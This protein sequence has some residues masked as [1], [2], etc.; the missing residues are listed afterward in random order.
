MPPSASAIS[1]VSSDLNLVNVDGTSAGNMLVRN[2][3]FNPAL[4]KDDPT[5][6]DKLLQGAATQRL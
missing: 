4:I 3:F 2:A 6:I 5:M 1:A